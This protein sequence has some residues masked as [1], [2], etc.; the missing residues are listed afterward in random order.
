VTLKMSSKV[1]SP[2]SRDVVVRCNTLQ[3]TVTPHC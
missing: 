2:K 1:G 3:H